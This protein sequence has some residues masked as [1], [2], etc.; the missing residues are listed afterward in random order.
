M[1]G[2]TVTTPAGGEVATV[3][4]NDR[5]NIVIQVVDHSSARHFVRPEEI[6]ARINSSVFTYTGVGEIGQFYEGNDDPDM[7]RMRDV[8]D[9]KASDAQKAEHARYN[10]YGYVLLFR[11]VI[12]NGGGNTL[13]INLT[14]LDTS[15]PMQTFSVSIGQCVDK[16]PLDPSGVK[17]PNLVV[18]DSNYGTGTVTIGNSFPL[19]LG[20][21]ATSGTEA[22]NDVVVSL[23][24]PEGVSL[25]GGSLSSYVGKMSATNMRDVTF[26]V[27]PSASMKTMV[28]NITV[29]LTGTGAITGKAV[30]GTTTIS[31]PVGQPDRFEVG[32]MTLPDELYLGNTGSVSLSYVN[33]G[34][35]PLSNLEATLSGSNLGAG[36]YQYLGNLNAGTE[37]SV[38]F[39]LT[40]DATGV[41]NGVITLNYESADGSLH[42]ISKDFSL[43][44]SE[45]QMPDDFGMDMPTDEPKGG[46]PTIGWVVIGVVAAGFVVFVLLLLRK[47]KQAKALA[48]LE[49][50]DTD[51]ED[52]DEDL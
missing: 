16:D 29:N 10:Y 38:D 35:N 24:L 19:Y 25:T 31:V 48:A 3:N 8:R 52:H 15:K 30:T 43:M 49:G 40:P 45:M 28:A 46:F 12:Y 37:G 4:W 9:G 44:A 11:D 36:G 13:P 51:S 1:T 33:K 34:K 14:Y 21:Y 39:D 22:L 20:V 26:S 47:R 41:V 27:L 7:Q 6:V 50:D 5:V 23:T 32:Q 2:Y 42:S 17:T 18:R